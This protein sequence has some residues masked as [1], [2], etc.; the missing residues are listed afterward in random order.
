LENSCYIEEL[1]DIVMM[2]H[3]PEYYQFFY[4]GLSGKDRL[5]KSDKG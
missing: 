3:R 2:V 1:A 4:S 5:G